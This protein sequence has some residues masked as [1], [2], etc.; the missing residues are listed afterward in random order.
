MSTRKG[1]LRVNVI[2]ARGLRDTAIFGIQDP[3]VQLVYGSFKVKTAVH[4][5]G[6]TSPVWNESIKL[7]TSRD[8]PTKLTVKVKN[9]HTLHDNR[10][11]STEVDLSDVFA[12][13][14]EEV[15][16][17]LFT[18]DGR[19]KGEVQLA[20]TFQPFDPSSS[21][22][23]DSQTNL[24]AFRVQH[25]APSSTAGSARTTADSSVENR[26]QKLR[27]TPEPGLVSELPHA[28]GLGPLGQSFMTLAMTHIT[29]SKPD[30][31]E[32]LDD[33]KYL[34]LPADGQGT[35]EI[36]RSLPSALA[37]TLHSGAVTE[38]TQPVQSQ[39]CNFYPEEASD[40]EVELPAQAT[41]S[42]STGPL[43]VMPIEFRCQQPDAEPA[44]A[45][46]SACTQDNGSY[47]SQEVYHAYSTRQSEGSSHALPYRAH[48]GQG[49]DCE[50][51]AQVP[52]WRLMGTSPLH[53]GQQHARGQ[54]QGRGSEELPQSQGQGRVQQPQVPQWR[55]MGTSPLHEGQRHSQEQPQAQLQVPRQDAGQ[56][57]QQQASKPDWHLMG[58]APLHDAYSVSVSAP[59]TS[60]SFSHQNKG[61][62]VRP[63]TYA[64]MAV[65]SWSDKAARLGSAASQTSAIQ[66]DLRVQPSA[67]SL[68][69]FV[70]ADRPPSSSGGQ[71]FGG[72]TN[73]TQSHDSKQRLPF[74]GQSGGRPPLGGR[75]SPT[76]APGERWAPIPFSDL[77]INRKFSLTGANHDCR[78]VI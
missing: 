2:S 73:V 18:R 16:A 29:P 77:G 68:P 20:F 24:A 71:T 60:L 30:L 76:P 61:S 66:D 21:S 72:F 31:A 37:Q 52:Q 48:R 62:V 65:G 34:K 44:A 8:A 69:S 49:Q 40:D 9:A 4:K 56:G 32:S 11:G 43:P 12:N 47:S 39:K 1:E 51:Q 41:Q 78:S 27:E 58:T 22:P 19:Q 54:H 28:D 23:Q 10:V 17:P 74:E 45:S 35:S 55:L 14:H 50:Q 64:S 70:S 6:G 75:S 15:S 13:N 38:P 25:P 7:S 63:L 3:Y 59:R 42:S 33:H 67:P 57:K 26:P 46:A 5:D 36:P 53:D